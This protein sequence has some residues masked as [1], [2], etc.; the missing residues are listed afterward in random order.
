MR[1]SVSVKIVLSNLIILSLL[2]FSTAAMMLGGAQQR[3]Q[4]RVATDASEIAAD[5]VLD[6]LVSVKNTNIDVVQIQQWLTDI[7]A[8]RA[9]D[10]LNDGFDKAA[11][12]K[13]LAEAHLAQVRALAIE[14]GATDILAEIDQVQKA[15]EPY[16]SLGTEMANAYIAG[17]PEAGNKMMGNFDGAAEAMSTA[18]EALVAK[19]DTVAG[20]ARATMQ[21]EL[22]QATKL[23][24]DISNL[25]LA[26]TVIGLVV[27]LVVMAVLHMHI[28]K[29]LAA[30]TGSLRRIGDGELNVVV[31]AVGKRSDEIAEMARALAS[32]RDSTAENAR[33]RAAQKELELSAEQGRRKAMENMAEAVESASRAAVENVSNETRMMDETAEAMAAS[34]QQVS[35]N[36]ESVAAAAEQALANAQA[37]AG[38]TE[39]LTASIH[40]IHA[41]VSHAMT[42]S[43]KAVEHGDQT[44]DTIDSLS[45]V[46]GQISEVANLIRDIASQTN[47]LALNASIE[48]ARAGE[49]GK[50]FAVVANEV[51]NLANQ[52]THSTDQITDKITQVQNATDDAVKAVAQIGLAIRDMDAIS[53]TIGAAMDQQTAA[54]QEIAR[55]VTET[56]SANKEVA[57]RIAYVSTEAQGTGE[58]AAL[59]QAV[60]TRVSD[61]VKE[62]RQTLVRVVRTATSDVDRR[63][64]ARIAIGA[65]CSVQIG[66]AKAVDA[67]LV[68]MSTGGAL[69]EGVDLPLGAKATLSTPLFPT[70]LPFTVVAGVEAGVSVEFTL[71]DLQQHAL[72]A[73][74]G[75]VAEGRK[76]A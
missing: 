8:T 14:I 10:G 69:I 71:T 47:L 44:K 28:V 52:T 48:A 62:L 60:S 65:P 13:T 25:T 64:D 53:A 49:A 32:L 4:I 1:L 6:F 37:V 46:V 24:S 34:A 3:Q 15:L 45:A 68:N 2:V 41:Q 5:K 54:T 30:M 51:K 9:L 66:K 56:A 33:L 31:P 67:R 61:G 72:A 29:P 43:R 39:E 26:L 55:N 18:L 40:E 42:V 21:A 7:S 11:E 58:K 74:L 17:G 12:S 23:A 22:A 20:T 63:R 57:R 16:Y 73:R 59:V 75:D 50:G 38:A 35:E 36:A 76:S 27:A 70:A 19:A